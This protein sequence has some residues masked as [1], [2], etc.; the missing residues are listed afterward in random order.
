MHS[1]S[2]LLHLSVMMIATFVKHLHSKNKHSKQALTNQVTSK[3]NCSRHLLMAGRAE[4]LLLWSKGQQTLFV[5]KVL[6]E[7][8]SAQMF[9]IVFVSF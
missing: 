2:P 8:N 4:V 3:C 5:N 7:H 9:I 1:H 6:L